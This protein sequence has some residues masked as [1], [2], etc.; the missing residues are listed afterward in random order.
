MTSSYSTSSGISR[1][2]RRGLALHPLASAVLVLLACQAQA[3]TAPAAAPSAPTARL[4]EVTVTGNPLGSETVVAPAAQLSGDD[5]TLRT[6]STLGETLDGLPGVSSTYFGPNASRPIIRGLDGDRIRVLQNSGA[7]LDASALSF[8]HAV[9]TEAL[10]TE[11][12]EVLRGP[13][14]LLYGGS[15]VGGVVNVIDN[16]IPREPLNGVDGKVEASGAT[17][18]GERAGAAMIEG[19]NDRFAVHADVFDRNTDDVR[20]PKD[21]DCTKPGSPAQARRICNSASHTRGGAVG[22]TAFFD[23]GYLGLSASTYRS[24][25]GTVAEDD[26]TIGMRSNRYALDG[27]WRLDAGPLQ[28]VRVQASHTDYRHTEFE[29]G[30]PGTT[31]RNAGN[32]LRVEAKH[33]PIGR[34]QGVVGLQAEAS[35]FS[36]VGEE[37]FAPRSRSQS[38]A[39]FVHEEL[40]TDW[41]KLTFGARTER[42]TVE[43]FGLAGVD[44]FATGKHDFNPH[45]AAVGALV[46]LTPAWQLTSN[47]SYTQRA[48]K[49]YELFAN[50]PHVA[51]VAWETGNPNLGLE[52]STSLDLGAAW[53]SGPHRFAVTGFVS[54]FSNYIGLTPTGVS[55]DDDGNAVP[56]GTADSLP[57]Y[58]YQGMRARFYGLEAS[59]NVRL[60]G[61]SGLVAPS[62]S[63]LGGG[64]T[65]DLQMRGDLVR[66]SNR[67]TGQ[68]LPRISPLRLGSTLLWAGGPWRAGLGFDYLAA[69]NRVPN[70]GTRATSAYTLWNASLGYRTQWQFGATRSNVLWYARLDNITDKLAYSPTSILTTTAY[71]KAPLPGRSLKVGVKVDF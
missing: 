46:N 35:R 38:T 13:A 14:A 9:P 39:L 20:V 19:G 6:R 34:L 52:K 2:A 61:D 50:G 1:S 71:P 54:Q 65:L 56:V 25:Y 22:G 21:L 23:R 31:F 47:L 29:G 17:G 10:T 11:R 27:L 53:K 42:D 7:T 32:D 16:R 41:G 68:P 18:N 45:S 28:S 44:R 24:D 67:D 5:L 3:Q 58:L 26:V 12:I 59:G 48:P 51:T 33:A 36:A 15:A 37:A 66:A 57:E 4:S 69:Q 40:G 62:S 30:A 49:D 60:V 55:R 64:S 70:D 63:V 8:D 43:S